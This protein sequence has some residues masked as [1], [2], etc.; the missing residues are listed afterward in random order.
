LEN[1]LLLNPSK[2][3]AILCGMRVQCN[4]VNTSSGLEVVGTVV[5]F[6][7]CIQLLGFKLDPAIS[8]NHHVTELV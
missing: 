3:E 4:K 7:D 5:K 1:R 2:T 6:R 8:M